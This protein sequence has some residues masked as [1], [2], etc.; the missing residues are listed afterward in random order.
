M[1]GCKPGSGSPLELR[2]CDM[3]SICGIYYRDDRKVEAAEIDRMVG[4]LAHWGPD[5]T[6]RW[7]DGALALGHLALWTTP[8]AVGEEGPLALPDAR[9]VITADARIDNREDLMA[10]LDACGLGGRAPGDVELIARAYLKWGE[11]CLDHLVG[12]F[13]FALWDE[14]ARRLF[15]ARD[16][17]GLRPFYYFADGEGFVFG[18]EIKAV[19]AAAD[20][21]RELNPL[22]LC[23]ATLGGKLE[24]E[25]TPFRSITALAPACALSVT[26][27]G[28]KKWRYWRL[29]PEREIRLRRDEDYVDAFEE[30]FQQAIDARLRAPGGVASMLS[31]GLDATAVTHFA[32]H[33]KRFARDR[34]TAY[35]W[36]L[37]E[38]DSWHQRD[39]REYVEAYLASHP[40]AHRYII[41]DPTQ[42]FADISEIRRLHDGP[43]L[44]PTAYVVKPTFAA[45]RAQ[46]IR[47]LLFGHGGDE[48][49]SYDPPNY[50]LG[51]FTGGKWR[52]LAGEA[53]A[54]AQRA[55]V[56]QWKAWKNQIFRPLGRRGFV[57]KSLACQDRLEFFRN[58][59]ASRKD[60]EFALA[61]SMVRECGMLEY[62]ESLHAPNRSWTHL[63]RR[64]Q[65]DGIVGSNVWSHIATRLLNGSVLWSSEC[66]FPYLDRRVVEYCVALPQEQH[67][68]D[69]LPRRLLRRAAERRIPRKIA[70]RRD[71][72]PTLPDFDRGLRQIEAPVTE[73]LRR[74]E[75]DP[76][77]KEFLAVGVLRRRFAEFFAQAP[78][79]EPPR[80][81]GMM[82]RSVQLGSFL[83]RRARL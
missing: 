56:P 55:S 54:Q 72:S 16:Q 26:A 51:L 67:R 39:E 40:V 22:Y 27:A 57:A 31:G 37:R 18:S 15:C 69:G 66:R 29:D 77:V 44:S 79:S 3:S 75:S 78:E 8:E 21:P 4:L 2:L 61:D 11:A 5:R 46:N 64:R 71:K 59:V 20:L 10:K 36:A 42:M 41:P 9:V 14:R 70:T 28:V 63:V 24:G 80:G 35:T 43:V 48:V 47:V 82:C 49:A 76:G 52:E 74:W 50:L 53:R 30:V 83:E 13:A 81:L 62:L 68:R 32:A 34:L 1:A 17:F 58:I 73:M 7:M 33:S 12:D 60:S 6:G 23:L 65:I 38:G 19:L 25:Q 45:A